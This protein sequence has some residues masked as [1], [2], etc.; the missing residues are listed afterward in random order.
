MAEIGNP[1]RVV[2]RERETEPAVTPDFFCETQ[3]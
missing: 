2:R 1:E 3:S